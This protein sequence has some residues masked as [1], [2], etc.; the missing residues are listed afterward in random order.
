MS[1]RSDGVPLALYMK[2]LR[3]GDLVESHAAVKVISTP[4]NKSEID[5][6]R[7]RDFRRKP[8]EPIFREWLMILSSE[9]QLMESFK[10]VQTL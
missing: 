4:Q 10:G 2:L 8:P 7:Q 5:S 1:D 9:I 6:L 3:R